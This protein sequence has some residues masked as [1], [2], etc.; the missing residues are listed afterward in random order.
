MRFFSLRFIISVKPPKKH[1]KIFLE[2]CHNQK[3]TRFSKNS[4]KCFSELISLFYYPFSK[5][6][7]INLLCRMQECPE[8]FKSLK[9]K[10]N[11]EGQPKFKP[12][13]FFKKQQKCQLIIV[14]ITDNDRELGGKT[15]LKPLKNSLGEKILS[16]SH[17]S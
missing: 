8:Y 1:Q 2:K 3:R 16:T 9:I 13:L 11:H 17:S 7:F 15:L 5:L 12:T 6:C 4:K 10:K 14:E